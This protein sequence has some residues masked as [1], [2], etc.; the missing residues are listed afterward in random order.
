MF[1]RKFSVLGILISTKIY[2]QSVGGTVEGKPPKEIC[3]MIEKGE[4]DAKEP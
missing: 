2:S 3:A 4:I 1:A